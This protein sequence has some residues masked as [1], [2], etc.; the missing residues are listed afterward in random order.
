MLRAVVGKHPLHLLHPGN[1]EH[2]GEE[3]HHADKPFHQIEGQ[4]IVN[5]AV[6]EAA[7][8]H[9]QQEEQQN[10]QPQAHGDGDAH[11]GLLEFLIPQ[12]FFQPLV[13]FGWLLL[14]FLG[15]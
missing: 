7:D 11:H 3:N 13:K 15:G 4:I 14:H 12:L 2:I 6:K 1:E 5:P 10:G 8:D 9:G